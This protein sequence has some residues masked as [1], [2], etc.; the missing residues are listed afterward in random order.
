VLLPILVTPLLII[1][2]F[3][4]ALYD[5]VGVEPLLNVL[6][7]PVPDIVSTPVVVFS[8][9]VTLVPKASVTVSS[10]NAVDT[11]VSMISM[12]ISSAVSLLD[13]F[14]INSLLF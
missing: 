12:T 3:I 6:I 1:T 13:V 7:A 9:P 10:A 4:V 5:A 14:F 2:V 8:T 11:D